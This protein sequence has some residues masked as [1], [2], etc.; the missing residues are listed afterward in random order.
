[1]K[2]LETDISIKPPKNIH[3]RLAPQNG[4]AHNYQMHVLAGVID[5]D[6]QVLDKVL[7]QNLGDKSVLIKYGQRI[8]HMICEKVIIPN[9]LLTDNLNKIAKKYRSYGNI[10]R[11]EQ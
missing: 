7:L 8:A 1:M 2:L 9:M 3:I 11:T 6:Y 10:E 5:T 4:I